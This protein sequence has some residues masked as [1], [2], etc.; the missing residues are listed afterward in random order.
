MESGKEGV[1]RGLEC[2]PMGV[3]ESLQG[4]S[5]AASGEEGKQTGPEVRGVR[6]AFRGLW[7]LWLLL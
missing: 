6:D 1:S 3:L 4:H 5:V 7:G 2:S